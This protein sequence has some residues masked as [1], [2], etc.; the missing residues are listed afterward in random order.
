MERTSGPKIPGPRGGNAIV[1]AS[2]S[3][4]TARAEQ[5]QIL[6]AEVCRHFEQPQ[7]KLSGLC[8]QPRGGY[9]A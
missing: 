5:T 3:L 7:P 9:P 1:L 4:M 8:F 6:A 2:C